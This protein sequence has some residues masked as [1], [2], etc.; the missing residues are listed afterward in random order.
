M[1]STRL[2]GSPTIQTSLGPV[3]TLGSSMNGF[4][5]TINPSSVNSYQPTPP[6]LPSAMWSTYRFDPREYR[7]TVARLFASSI[8]E[9][10][11]GFTTGLDKHA[12]SL[13]TTMNP[14][15]VTVKAVQWEL[16]RA[17]AR[18]QIEEL[19][20]V[21]EEEP[22]CLEESLVGLL[23]AATFCF[24][25]AI[26]IFALRTMSLDLPKGPTPWRDITDWRGGF[27]FGSTL[28]QIPA[29]SSFCARVDING[30]WRPVHP[31]T[32]RITLELA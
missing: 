29:T 9:K 11:Q 12:T 26:G 27:Q 19:A 22:R 28:F 4:G 1:S 14:F 16:R 10:G 7:G 18:D 23:T 30:D 5:G 3:N 13:H 25:A 8:G 17:P 32:L 15:P 2:F 24:E 21:V 6:P 31:V 20:M